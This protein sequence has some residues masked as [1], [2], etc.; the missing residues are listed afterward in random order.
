MACPVYP[1]KEVKMLVSIPGIVRVELVCPSCQSCW[2]RLSGC[3]QPSARSLFK[4]RL[5][6]YLSE[7][8]QSFVKWCKLNFESIAV[9]SFC[10]MWAGLL[11]W[12]AP[13]SEE[14]EVRD[15]LN[16]L[17]LRVSV[18]DSVSGDCTDLSFSVNSLHPLCGFDGR[19]LEGISYW[20]GYFCWACA[21]ESHRNL[22][23]KAFFPPRLS[24]VHSCSA[25]L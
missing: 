20:Q 23:R 22:Q 16:L 21:V 17:L 7:T 24:W 9:G 11:G 8:P 2:W 18:F 5:C 12:P 3:Q 1:R 25:S 13:W 6:I 19:F 15:L 10:L 4:T 14:M